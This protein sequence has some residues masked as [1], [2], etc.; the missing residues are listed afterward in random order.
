MT[1]QRQYFFSFSKQIFIYK[2][3]RFSDIPF[4]NSGL[5]V[6]QKIHESLTLNFRIEI[7]C[8]GSPPNPEHSQAEIGKSRILKSRLSEPAALCMKAS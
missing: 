2:T 7:F 4:Y 6:Y 8:P 3:V 5:A 1:N